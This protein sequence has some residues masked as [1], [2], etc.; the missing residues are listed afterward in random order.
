MRPYG[1]SAF[2]V[3]GLSIRGFHDILRPIAGRMIRTVEWARRHAK[4][5]R[6]ISDAAMFLIS[7]G[8]SHRIRNLHASKIRQVALRAVLSAVGHVEV[9]VGTTQSRL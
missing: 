6:A 1:R 9:V 5:G 2:G 7:A 4:K 8:I 3:C